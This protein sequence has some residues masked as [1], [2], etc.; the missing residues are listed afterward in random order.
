[1]SIRRTTPL[2][3]AATLGCAILM[4][5]D[6]AKGSLTN[7]TI[8]RMVNQGIPTETILKAIQVAESV[9]FSMLPWDL[10]YLENAKVP[11]GIIKAMA[12]R[13]NGRPARPAHAPLLTVPGAPMGETRN[14]T[15]PSSA[16]GTA[17]LAVPTLPSPS[18]T[19]SSVP[20]R[21]ASPG[22][23]RSVKIH[24][25]VTAIKSANEFEIDEYRIM[26]DASLVLEF[27]KA[28]DADDKTAFDASDIRVGTEME[29]RGDL[30]ETS[31][32]LKARSIKVNLDE[33]RRVKR[34]ALMEV[35]PDLRKVGNAW[36]GEVRADGQHVMVNEATAVT[37]KLN[38]TQK[39]AAKAQEKAARKQKDKGSEGEAG[40]D[41]EPGIALSR[42]DQISA[43]TFVNYDG[44]RQKGGAILATKVEFTQNELT[45]GE[46]RLWKSLTPKVK[47]SDLTSG[48]PGELTIRGAGKY[49]LVPSAEAQEYVQD[50]GSRLIPQFQRDLPAGDPL[51]I[52][53]QFFLVDSKV[54]NAS[55]LPNGTVLVNS[56][57][58]RAL[59]NE[60]E[61][62]FV[63]GHEIAHAT[64]KH[65]YRQSQYHKNIK[66]AL[67]IGG[68]VAA[69]Y[70]KGGITELTTLTEA[71]IRNG[72]Q[73]S[74]ENQADRLGIEHMLAAGYDPREA[75]RV[76]K[77]MS[78]HYGDQRTNFFWSDH[79]N[80]TTR[81]SY[82]MAELKNN[83]SDVDFD[84]LKR[85]RGE[86]FDAVVRS[87]N[88]RNPSKGKKLKVKY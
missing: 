73:R 76:W 74:L 18:R 3:L 63:L 62:A 45:R 54:P 36:E 19:A 60:A 26:K 20:V 32:E 13:A 58:L 79:D 49:K 14:A 81:R 27:E 7:E 68:A 71:A 17:P 69:A 82:L 31:G 28:E 88:F 72:Y 2:W 10:T 83:Y 5:S 70:G 50:L 6:A 87:L 64:Q 61:L 42:T 16:P 47:A 8:A 51:K 38:S 46:A 59:E 21:G 37:I 67:R 9:Q 57:M 85:D 56:E 15:P 34:T 30:D 66:M 23:L 75:P 43:N 25:Y 29:I 77:V 1:M 53:F 39:K 22:K 4:G 41:E 35:A 80:N 78:L 44:V 48:R 55:A 12:A 40:V 24:G 65:A 86:R 52:P 33:H 11:E 84:S